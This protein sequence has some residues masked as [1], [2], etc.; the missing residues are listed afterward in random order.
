MHARRARRARGAPPHLGCPADTESGQARA[1]GR[2]RRGRASTRAA[3]G[4]RAHSARA[5][6]CQI[7]SASCSMADASVMLPGSPPPARVPPVASA[8]ALTDGCDSSWVAAVHDVL[9]ITT[10]D[11]PAATG[12]AAVRRPQW[13]ACRAEV[14]LRVTGCGRAASSGQA[15]RNF[16]ESAAAAWGGHPGGRR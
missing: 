12:R 15:G 14:C 7:A 16:R 10:Q 11:T 4:A 1:S 9:R 13:E 5:P 2:G 8:A 3:G 6:G